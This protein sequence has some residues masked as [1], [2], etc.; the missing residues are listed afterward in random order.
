[1]LQIGMEVCETFHP[2]EPTKF[3]FHME[4]FHSVN[5]LQ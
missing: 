1:M 3:G 4:P 2:G 5:H